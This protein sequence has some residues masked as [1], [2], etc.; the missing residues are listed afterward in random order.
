MFSCDSKTSNFMTKN[1]ESKN[2]F[3]FAGD[4]FVGTA[5]LWL[6]QCNI[7]FECDMRSSS[8]RKRSEH[9]RG[10]REEASGGHCQACYLHTGGKIG[11]LP[12]SRPRFMVNLSSY[13][14]RV[15]VFHSPYRSVWICG[16]M[17]PP[18]SPI[19]QTRKTEE[20]AAKSHLSGKRSNSG[21]Q[22]GDSHALLR[23]SGRPSCR[24][25][26]PFPLPSTSRPM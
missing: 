26:H 8:T 20:V 13:P 7:F 5:K 18:L 23:A 19:F 15:N 1:L 12:T 17:M 10:S 24:I 21:W 6:S 2:Y 4:V 11:V 9:R 25:A 16:C 3:S 14:G 22:P